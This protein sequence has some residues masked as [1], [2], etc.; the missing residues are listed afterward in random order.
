VRFRQIILNLVSNGIE[1]Y[2][3][4]E[5]TGDERTVIIRL[6]RKRSAALIQV[7]DH[8]IGIN[9]TDRDKIFRPF[10]TTKQK[11]T[12]I[13]LFIVKQVVENDF[14][15]TITLASDR[16]GTTFRV[17]LPKSYYANS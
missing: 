8:G 16:P 13:G 9:P 5:Q 12:G 10:Y 3:S 15:G 1:A 2:S 7:T 11:G 6:E 17:S 14:K 4:A